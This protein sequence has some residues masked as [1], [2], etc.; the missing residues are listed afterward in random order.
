MNMRSMT[1]SIICTLAFAVSNLR[2]NEG[3]GGMSP[4]PRIQF[5]DARSR[6]LSLRF[7]RDHIA[8]NV[9]DADKPKI[10]NR[11]RDKNK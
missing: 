5:M 7:D 9:I 4:G 3:N 11:D 6:T 10:K 1:I 2:Y 8:L